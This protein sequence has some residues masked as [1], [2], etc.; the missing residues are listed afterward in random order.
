MV[1]CCQDPFPPQEGGLHV[2][3]RLSVADRLRGGGKGKG[4]NGGDSDSQG[5]EAEMYPCDERGMEGPGRG[6]RQTQYLH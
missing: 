2:K 4:E 1:I 5:S 6:Y 3:Q